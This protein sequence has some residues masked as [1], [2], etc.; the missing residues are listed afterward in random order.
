MQARSRYPTDL[1]DRQWRLIEGLVPAIKP[2]GRPEVHARREI[3]NA[4][5][6]L[7][8]HRV[9]TADAAQ[10]LPAVADRVHVFCGLA[11]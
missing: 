9:R 8:S 2:G 10:G 7:D 4:V 5:L 11:R 3:V 1:T 6:Y